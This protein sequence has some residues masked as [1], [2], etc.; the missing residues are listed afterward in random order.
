MGGAVSRDLLQVRTV[1]AEPAALALPRGQ[2]VL[3]LW[4][5]AEVVEVA[6][7]L[8]IPQVHGA[9]TSV[10]RWVRT[11]TEVLAL[12]V[13]KTLTARKN[14]RSANWIAPSTANGCAM[15][16]GYCYVPR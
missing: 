9:D 1:Y 4:P 6:S 13:R 10:D 14:E 5:D 8:R 2:Q 16:C 7:A 11:K 12:G 3:A 15:A